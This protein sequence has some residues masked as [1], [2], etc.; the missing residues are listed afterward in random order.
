MAYIPKPRTESHVKGIEAAM[1]VTFDE[2]NQLGA[3]HD[4]LL[5][6][7]TKTRYFTGEMEVTYNGLKA[8]LQAC[9]DASEAY[10]V[11]NNLD[12]WNRPIKKVN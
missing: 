7:K 1:G 9:R 2:F 3:H 11:A 10:R 6:I 12:R 8:K 5:L 4:E